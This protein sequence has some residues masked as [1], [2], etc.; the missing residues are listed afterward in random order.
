[1]VWGELGYVP[2][3]IKCHIKLL[4]YHDRLRNL[5]D[6]MLVKRAY[7][8]ALH[9]HEQGFKTWVSN[10]W[11]IANKYQ[12]N[13]ETKTSSFRHTVKNQINEHFM[14]YWKTSVADIA[15]NPILGTYNLFKP[16][17]KFETYL[18]VVKDGRYRH[19]LTKFRLSSHTLGIERGR[20]TNTEVNER[21]CAYCERIDDERHFI[22][23]C[24]VIDYESQC[25]F[26]KVNYHYPDFRDLD[27][28]DKFKYLLMSENSKILTWL[29]KF[30]YVGFQKKWWFKWKS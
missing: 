8:E 6:S 27:D 14:N 28:L 26:E 20:H 30:I 10:V 29:S 24:D 16:D 11:E 7:N 22:L 18:E 19:A 12:L 15:M 23:Y 4:H 13:I 1:M 3:S 21:L 2:P 17:F 9:L 25:L 5:P